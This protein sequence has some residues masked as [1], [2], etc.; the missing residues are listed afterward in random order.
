MSK[1]CFSVKLQVHPSQGSVRTMMVE[2]GHVLNIDGTN[3]NKYKKADSD[4]R[5]MSAVSR[6]SNFQVTSDV[7]GGN[8]TTEGPPGILSGDRVSV[9]SGASGRSKT[10]SQIEA[11][12][13]LPWYKGVTV[14]DVKAIMPTVLILFAGVLVLIFVIPYAFSSVF[15]QL[16]NEVLVRNAKA[17]KKALYYEAKRK[18]ELEEEAA[19]NETLAL[20]ASSMTF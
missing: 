16:E 2:E 5:N 13:K 7:E 17:M 20:E 10:T 18:Q 8:S 4:S 9:L 19:Y 14:K 11:M 3:A 6:G 1:R 12:E 15:K